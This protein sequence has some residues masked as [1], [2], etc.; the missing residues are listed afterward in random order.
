MLDAASEK[1]LCNESMQHAAELF[2]QL[3]LAA[4]LKNR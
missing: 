1:Y 3:P 2:L 4:R